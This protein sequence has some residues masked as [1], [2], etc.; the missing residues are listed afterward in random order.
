MG[1]CSVLMLLS[2]LT[3]VGLVLF[4]VFMGAVG[5]FIIATV[6]SIFFAVRTPR[7]RERGKKLGALIAIPLVLYAVSIPLLVY[8]AVKWIPLVMAG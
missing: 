1:G 7:R 6:V 8:F 5:L 2:L 3:A 4:N